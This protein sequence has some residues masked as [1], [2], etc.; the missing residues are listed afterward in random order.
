MQRQ[1]NRREMLRNS[2]LAAGGLALS[3]FLARALGAEES[4]PRKKVLFFTKSQGFQHSVITRS[5]KNPE[6]L[7]WAEQILTEVGAK[8]GFDVTCSKDGTLF[9][10]ENLKQ[11]DV[12]A[13][14][15]TGDLTKDSDKPAWKEPGMGE[16]GKEAF[17]N[18]IKDGKGFIGFH[19]ATDTFHSAGYKSGNLLR[20]MDAGGHDEFDP[21]IKMIGGEFSIHGAQQDAILHTIDP[22]FP[23][24]EAFNGAKFKE[25]W[26]SL[27]NFAPDLH[28]ILAQECTGMKGPMYQRGMYPETWARRHGQGPVFYTSMGHRE[29]VWTRP[30][31]QA[32]VVGALKWASGQT[33][34]DITPNIE[35]VTPEANVKGA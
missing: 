11:Y 29:D 25:E 4:G 30:D 32:L 15:T 14:Y 34:V 33:E 23:G 9:T 2:A 21:Y 12:I 22:K 19:C 3:P 26:Y 31:F 24:A 8:H 1:I 35:Q 13:F 7:A 18:A 10:P 17:L 16:A 27:K 5:S 20:S 28:V 6:K